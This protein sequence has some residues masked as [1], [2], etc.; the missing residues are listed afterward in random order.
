MSLV[1]EGLRIIIRTA[2]FPVML[3][4]VL[5]KMYLKVKDKP[6]TKSLIE[7][8]RK[9]WNKIKPKAEEPQDDQGEWSYQA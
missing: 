1:R 6:E 7:A 4:Y 3:F 9:L 5:Y 2:A 8:Y